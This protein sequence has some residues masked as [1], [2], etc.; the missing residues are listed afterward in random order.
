MML[1]ADKMSIVSQLLT[2][3]TEG[4]RT[5]HVSSWFEHR[6]NEKFDRLISEFMPRRY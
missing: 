3:W 6:D 5:N 2:Q 1:D 4:G